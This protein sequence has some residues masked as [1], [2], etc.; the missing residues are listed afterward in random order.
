MAD[1]TYA[2]GLASALDEAIAELERAASKQA[3]EQT[4][5]Q[6]ARGAP[7]GAGYGAAREEEQAPSP[8][9]SSAPPATE[10]QPAPYPPPPPAPAQAPAPGASYGGVPYAPP[11]APPAAAPPPPEVIASNLSMQIGRLETL[12]SWMRDDPAFGRLVDSL[13]GQQVQAAERRQRVFSGVLSVAALVVGWLLT[14]FSPI[15]LQHLLGK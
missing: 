11:S 9:A 2:K 5:R 10:A 8:V 3:G 4:D 15:G 14:A 12:R 1:G 6:R 13:I 7:A